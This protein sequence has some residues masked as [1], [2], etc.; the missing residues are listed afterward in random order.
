M[1]D[2]A[3]E[4]AGARILDV[5]CGEGRFCRMLTDRGAIT[6]GIDP[7]LRL[8]EQARLQHSSG[9]YLKSRAEEMPFVDGSFDLVVS[10]ITLVDI[11]DFRRAIAE[12]AR[13]LA[14]KGRLLVANVQSFASTRSAA[15]YRNEAGEKLHLAVEDYF[16]ER[17]ML[18]EW[19]GMSI[20]NWHRPLEQYFSAY[21]SNGLVLKHFAEPR[22]KLEDV[23][24]HPAMMDEYRVPLF[25]VMRW[26]K[27]G[28]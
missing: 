15:W 16:D 17:S 4:I 3:G 7:T 27:P 9:L 10:Y 22:P 11:P 13:V 14:P 12:M 5:G 1:L 28:E 2:A 24:R 19:S 20:L 21:L 25:H 8:V 26:E 6:V 18:L 23:Q